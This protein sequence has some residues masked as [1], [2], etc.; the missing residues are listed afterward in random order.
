VIS[1]LKNKFF[2]VS[3]E[4]IAFFDDIQGNV[5]MALKFKIQA[6]LFE[7]KAGFNEDIKSLSLD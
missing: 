7:S 6:F 1:D 2:D 3:P 4:E 5:D